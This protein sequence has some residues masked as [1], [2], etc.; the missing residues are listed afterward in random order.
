[1]FHL[2][3]LTTHRAVSCATGDDGTEAVIRAVHAL[4]YDCHRT[5]LQSALT[6]A[7]EA[8]ALV[9]RDTTIYQVPRRL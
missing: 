6:A 1:M 4:G 5:T 7:G 3:K 8:P 2:S 9:P